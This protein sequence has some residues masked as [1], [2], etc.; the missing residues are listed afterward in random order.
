MEI[1]LNNQRA[2]AHTGGKPFSTALP[3]I[4]FIHGALHDHSVF[5]LLARCFANQGFSVLALDLPGHGRSDGPPPSSVQEA[6]SWARLVLDSLGVQRTA[7]VGHSLGSLIALEA[8]AQA[9]QRASALVLLGTAA[10]MPVSDHL[11]KAAA[12]DPLAAMRLINAF[13]HSSLANKPGYPGPGTWLRGANQALMERMKNGWLDGNLCHHDLMLCNGYVGGLTAA[14][15]V[16]CPS[17]VVLAARDQ[18]TPPKSASALIAALQASV[19]SL[20]C[21][22]AVMQEAP[23]ELRKVLTEALLTRD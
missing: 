22:H 18:M 23:E 7:W 2:F 5:T 17:T 8:A 14:Y 11:Q 4:V 1:L 6:A 21:G 19:H 20:D 15:K 9:P 10:P 13:S 16:T 12:A 3:C